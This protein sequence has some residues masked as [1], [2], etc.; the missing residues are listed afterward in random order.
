M[1]MIRE[2][3]SFGSLTA[4]DFPTSTPANLAIPWSKVTHGKSGVSSAKHRAPATNSCI[5]VLSNRIIF[6][7]QLL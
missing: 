2:R 4:E 6:S 1:R 5:E 3:N 7:C